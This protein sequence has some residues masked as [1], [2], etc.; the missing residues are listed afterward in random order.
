VLK[1]S[2]W[3]ELGMRWKDTNLSLERVRENEKHFGI[4]LDIAGIPN[5]KCEIQVEHRDFHNY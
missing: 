5:A 3:L 4:A 2:W 1:A